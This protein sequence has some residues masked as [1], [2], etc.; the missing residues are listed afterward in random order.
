M[1]KQKQE[2]VTFP[3][4]SIIIVNYNGR[5]LLAKFLPSIQ[6]LSYPNFEIIV[7]DNGSIDGSVQFLK[8]SFPEVKVV[9]LKENLGWG[10]GNNRGA[11]CSKGDYLWFVNNDLEVE[12][13]SLT[14]L[15]QYMETNPEVG[16]CI[17]LDIFY[18]D[19]RHISAAGNNFDRFG[20]V[21]RIGLGLGIERVI[22][23]DPY[24]ISYA[25]GSAPLIRRDVYTRIGAFD[26]DIFLLG[27]DIDISIRCWIY[28]YKVMFVPSSKIYHVVS[29]TLSVSGEV[30]GAKGFYYHVQS[31]IHFMLKDL[32]VSTLITALPYFILDSFT[33]AL[34]LLGRRKPQFLTMWLKALMWNVNMLPKTLRKRKEIQRNRK[35]PDSR[36]L[37]LKKK[38]NMEPVLDDR[39]Y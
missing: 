28:G 4:V 37:N 13:D 26:D 2:K 22:L 25:G 6:K 39:G 36:F 23:S 9:A 20:R 38:I 7:V 17:P 11:E 21:S 19:K 33:G 8:K 30:R 35:V 3:L 31:G 5:E 12:R 27:D 14:N 1:E 16:I 34:I 32:Q 10:P 15:V 29:A 18:S 24:E